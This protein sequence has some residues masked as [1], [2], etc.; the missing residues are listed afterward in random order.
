MFVVLLVFVESKVS[1]KTARSYMVLLCKSHACGLL[2]LWIFLVECKRGF[3]SGLLSAYVLASVNDILRV[4][5]LRVCPLCVYD[6]PG[7]IL[8]Q[9]L[10]HHVVIVLAMVQLYRQCHYRAEG[11]GNHFRQEVAMYVRLVL[12]H[13]LR[14][15]V[16]LLTHLYLSVSLGQLVAL[17]LGDQVQ[18][19]VVAV[20]WVVSDFCTRPISPCHCLA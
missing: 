7:L 14:D 19:I 18:V 17:C 20:A 5:A 11:H 16:I 13:Q 8:C 2:V 6:L 15:E 1:M 10:L 4:C 12:R 9:F 3:L